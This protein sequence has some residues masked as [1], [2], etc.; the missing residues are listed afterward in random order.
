M[1]TTARFANLTLIDSSTCELV[2]GTIT[3]EIERALEI[4]QDS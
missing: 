3:T 2:L 1:P 4:T